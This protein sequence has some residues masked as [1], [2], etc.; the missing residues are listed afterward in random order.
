MN[1]SRRCEN[2]VERVGTGFHC[3]NN[4]LEANE[5][6]TYQCAEHTLNSGPSAQFSLQVMQIE[7][8]TVTESGRKILRYI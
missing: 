2:D 1:P 5:R 6:T 7:G 8:S 3:F 4:S